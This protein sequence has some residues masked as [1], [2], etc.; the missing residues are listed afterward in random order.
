MIM[1]HPTSW[2][3]YTYFVIFKEKIKVIRATVILARSTHIVMEGFCFAGVI[4]RFSPLRCSA[5]QVPEYTVGKMG[6]EGNNEG[7]KNY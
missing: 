6:H 4:T 2:S 5:V 1:Q 7:K 3:I